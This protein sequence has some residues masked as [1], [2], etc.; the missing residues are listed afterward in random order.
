MPNHNFNQKN[1]I[2]T[3]Q[4]KLDELDMENYRQLHNVVL[5]FSNNS[6]EI[7]KMFIATLTTIATILFTF[8]KENLSMDIIL[9]YI[10]LAA[11]IV[12]LL[13]LMIDAYT[14]YYQSKLRIIMKN[15]VIDIK[16]RNNII[17]N[18]KHEQIRKFHLL[19]K[20]VFNFSNNIYYFIIL[21]STLYLILHL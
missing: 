5:K 17:F 13:F 9:I 8:F 1:S 15:I 11:I 7:K 20:S 2:N 10:F 3:S 12:T 6:I 4:E 16:F 19:L 18:L 14:Y 21:L